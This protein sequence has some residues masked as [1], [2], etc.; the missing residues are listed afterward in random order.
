MQ[1]V[2]ERK[3][4]EV[5]LQESKALWQYALEGS[6]DGIWDWNVQT[7]EI[8]FSPA[9]KAMLGFEEDELENSLSQ[10][11]NLVH[12]DDRERVYHVLELHLQ[13]KTDQYVSEYRIRCKDGTYKWHFDRGR[14]VQRTSDGRPQRII[15]MNVDISKQKEIEAALRQSEATKQAMLEA[16]PDLLIRINRDGIRLDFISGGEIKLV[17][18]ANRAIHQSIYE[19]LSRRLADQRMYFIHQ[20][21]ETGKRQVYQHEIEIEG[22]LHYEETRIVPINVDEVLVMVRDIT[23]QKQAELTL[24][25]QKEILQAIFDHIPIML[26]FFNEQGQVELINREMEQVLGW[27]LSEWQQSNRL[28]E[29]C[30]DEAYY[31]Q[32]LACIRAV[33]NQ[34]KDLKARTVSGNLLD[35]SWT[36][37]RL[38]DGRGISIG[39]DISKRKR[40]EENLRQR[41]KLDRLISAVTQRIHQSLDLDEILH[42][43]VSEIRQV[44]QTDRVLVCRFEPDASGLVIAESVREDWMSLLGRSMVDEGLIIS[45][46]LQSY[47]DGQIQNTSDIFNS[48]LPE[49]YIE[50]LAHF[51]VRATLILPILRS[52][53]LWGLLMVQHCAE[54]RVWQSTEVELL[55]QLS[56]QMA[57]GIQQSELYQKLQQVNQELQ[58]LATH[59]E[60]TQLANRRY[61]DDYLDQEWNR[62]VRE[63]S[64]LAIILCDI[65]YFK[66]YNDT[67]GHLAG[68]ECLARVA[69]AIGRA[70]KRPADLA[71]RY[72]GEEFAIILP[73]T[74]SIGAIQVAQE[75]CQEVA[76]LKLAHAASQIQPW[77]TLSLGIACD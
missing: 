7:N 5:A 29:S 26:A 47:A 69:Q 23:D 24:Q 68:D 43:T 64:D 6:G 1:D 19:T 14:V 20:A 73:N 52:E 3:Q 45:S 27:S 67:Y 31:H 9:W 15:G 10:W 34:W 36:T 33:N 30:S 65:D 38:S 4:T 48:D 11:D 56:N 63:Q 71:A 70:I 40:I 53:T 28:V 37:I 66:L 25:K 61:F 35:T 50:I 57:I 72:G 75:I 77:I 59:D 42:T 32:L 39:Q 58:H 62:M 21:L 46:R 60:L 22:A 8:F 51:Q 13:G 2:T 76:Q 49:S 12:P 54:P 16:I 74:N 17:C 44:L 55:T 41:A 18:G